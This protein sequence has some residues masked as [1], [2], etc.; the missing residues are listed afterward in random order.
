VVWLY[1]SSTTIDG[2][3]L[4]VGLLDPVANEFQFSARKFSQF[5]VGRYGLSSTES[6]GRARPCP[7][8]QPMWHPLGEARSF[9]F[10]FDDIG[11][12]LKY[13]SM[14]LAEAEKVKEATTGCW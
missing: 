14:E 7:Y 11:Y 12:I 8:L 3:L 13:I 9:A 1:C 4:H 2:V 5:G 6:S 10:I